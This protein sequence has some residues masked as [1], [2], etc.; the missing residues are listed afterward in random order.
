MTYMDEKSARTEI[1]KAGRK[2]YERSLVAGSDGNLSVRIND[3][4]IIATPAGVSKGELTEDSLI[5]TDLE[6][7][8]MSGSGMPSSELK[9]HLALYKARDDILAVLH[10]HPPA[11]TAFALE[12]L[13]IG[14]NLAESALTFPGGVP[15]A[16]YEKPGGAAIAAGAVMHIGRKNALLLE[17]HGAVTVGENIESAYMRMETLENIAKTELYA[18]LLR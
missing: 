14:N 17:R 3:K 4:H 16:P 15:V 10:A 1:V 5:V 7:G 11:A 6:G 8:V 2:L 13:P 12:A 18:R 9:L